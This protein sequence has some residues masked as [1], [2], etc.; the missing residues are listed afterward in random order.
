MYFSRWSLVLISFQYCQ[1]TLMDTDILLFCLYHPDTLLTHCPH[2]AKN[3]HMIC[4]LN[5]LQDSIQGNKCTRTTHTS[6]VNITKCDS[7]RSYPY[8]RDHIA[9]W[10]DTFFI[11][12][13]AFKWK[14][15]WF[16][17]CK[18]VKRIYPSLQPPRTSKHT[19][20]NNHSG[21]SI[22]NPLAYHYFIYTIPS[23]TGL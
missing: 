9:P 17:F 20:I 10:E 12:S 14:C 21:N 16:I 15:I 13:Q 11:I 18:N 8:S 3:V 23:I 5:L 22:I 6:T 19:N 7:I 4:N 1:K 2:Y